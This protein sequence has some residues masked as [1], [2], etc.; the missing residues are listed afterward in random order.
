MNTSF[1]FSLALACALG[2]CATARAQATDAPAAPAA[3]P[4]AATPTPT[5]RAPTRYVG[6]P[7]YSEPNTGLQLPPGCAVEASWRARMG[8]SDHEVW[9]AACENV[10]RAWM[11]RRQVVELLGANQ[12]RLRFQVLDERLFAGESA[13]DSLSV[14][15]GGT[16]TGENGFIVY[17][18]RWRA[19]GKELKLT[20]AAGLIRA[21][22]AQ[23]RFVD[24][25]LAAA[26]C[27][28]FPEREAMMRQ[29]QQA[30]AAR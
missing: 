1:G 9:V 3:V 27:A 25:P 28:R 30:P 19:A 21:D 10:P 6:R 22:V 11:V 8:A 16:K 29:L 26:E 20:S 4:P 13:G 14:Q 15:C 5:P 17:G 12:A 24:A 2:L 23:Q 7:I 18:A